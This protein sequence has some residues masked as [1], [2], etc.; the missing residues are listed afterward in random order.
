MIKWIKSLFCGK[1][2]AHK[3]VLEK[4]TVSKPFKKKHATGSKKQGKRKC[5]K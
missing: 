3:K 2:P 5:Q 4:I 1:K